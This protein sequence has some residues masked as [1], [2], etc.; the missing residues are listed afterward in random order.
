MTL[1]LQLLAFAALASAM[2][3]TP[4]PLRLADRSKARRGARIGGVA[5]LCLS[6]LAALHRWPI[7]FAI[8]A[9]FG[10]ASVSAA[11]VLLALALLRPSSRSARSGVQ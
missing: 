8:L 3:A 10:L 9:W 1:L 2:H 7:G 6:I 5:L 4:R 11:S